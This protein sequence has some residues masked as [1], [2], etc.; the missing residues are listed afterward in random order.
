MTT[1]AA[2]MLDENM[3][4][5]YDGIDSEL[6]F[7]NDKWDFDKNYKYWGRR[8]LRNHLYFQA[9]DTKIVLLSINLSQGIL[10]CYIHIK[11]SQLLVKKVKKLI[12][13]NQLSHNIELNEEHSWLI[14]F[15]LMA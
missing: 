15:D 7:L 5:I 12:F 9:K 1:N 4:S 11:N 2:A 13:Q 6:G 14:L 3:N 8:S 10:I